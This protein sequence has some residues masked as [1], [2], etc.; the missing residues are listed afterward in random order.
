MVDRCRA[1]PLLQADHER[2]SELGKIGGSRQPEHIYRPKEHGNLKEDGTVSGVVLHATGRLAVSMTDNT[3]SRGSSSDSIGQEDLRTRKD[4]GFG[5]DHDFASEMG[6][7]GKT[8]LPV[9]L[10]PGGT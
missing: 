2:A 1:R 6:K 7:K 5:G 10:G 3:L 9:L 8:E 4:H